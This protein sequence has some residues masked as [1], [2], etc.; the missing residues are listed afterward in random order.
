MF[1][2]N[3]TRFDVQSNMKLNRK[4]FSTSSSQI[5]YS[6]VHN[7]L[8]LGLRPERVPPRAC[9]KD[10]T[11]RIFVPYVRYESVRVCSVEPEYSDKQEVKN[12]E[13]SN[14]GII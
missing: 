6:N 7:W 12:W 10:C 2:S 3:S 9:N 5:K 4:F 13:E 1:L 11:Y 14:P 8:P